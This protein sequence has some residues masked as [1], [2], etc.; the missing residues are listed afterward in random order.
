M[1]LRTVRSGLKVQGQD[2]E[3]TSPKGA[4]SFRKSSSLVANARFFTKSR[5]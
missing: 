3:K 5:R 4:K 1:Y 2:R